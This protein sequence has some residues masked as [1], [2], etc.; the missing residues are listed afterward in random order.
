MPPKR[1]VWVPI[2]AGVSGFLLGLFFGCTAGAIIATPE[3]DPDP[4][5]T[6]TAAPPRPKPRPSLVGVG[7]GTFIVGEDIQPGRYKARAAEG[8][9][10]WARLKDGRGGFTSIIANDATEGQSVVTIRPSDYAFETDG[11]TPWVK[12]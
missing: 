10:Y 5:V 4:V 2:L 8:I 3:V 1:P 9:C 6:V 12:Q 11:C 7:E